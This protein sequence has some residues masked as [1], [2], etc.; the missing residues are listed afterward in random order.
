MKL[1]DL[2][3]H[4]SIGANALYLEIGPFNF[5]VDSGIHP[6]YTGRQCLPAFDKIPAAHLDGI[7]LTHCHLDHLGSLPLLARQYPNAPIFTSVPSAL[8]APRMLHNSVSIMSLQRE[9]LNLKE[10]PLYTRSEV[11]RLV[12]RIFESPYKKT[13]ILQ[14]RGEE[15]AITFY[16]AG[17]VVGAASILFEY[18]HRRI[19]VTGDIS[20]QEQLTIPGASLPQGHVDTLIME[21]TRGAHERTATRAEES[22]RLLMAINDTLESGGS[23]L[24]PVFAL[25][26]MQETLMLLANA[27]REN[28]LLPAPIF[29]SGLG[30]DLADYFDELHRR[31][32]LVRF[33]RKLVKELH[34]HALPDYIHPRQGGVKQKGIYLISSGMVVEKTPSYAIAASLFEDPSSS[35]LF[36][37][38]CDP[39]TPGGEI[40]A[41]RH[42]ENYVFNS[43]EYQAQLKCRVERFDLSGH[44]DREDL[45]EMAKGFTPRSVV[46]TH[47][48]ADARVFFKDALAD[49]ATGEVLD[50]TP[51]VEYEV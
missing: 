20:F 7:I 40:L 43:L 22:E 50:P 34:A 16:P 14:S 51:G 2:N 19:F 48:D 12:P 44:A 45:V 31:T 11:E 28:N 18:K 42:G 35:I 13:R 24:I 33:S 5:V 49:V 37:G 25:G 32:G 15:I 47:G 26:R 27:R 6:K 4:G 8:L 30:V 3:S 38:Y 23:V 46:L 17:H 21:T 41:L 9:E 36:V 1:I 39:E 10:Y 29:C